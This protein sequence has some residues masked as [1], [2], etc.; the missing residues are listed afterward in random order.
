M[1]VSAKAGCAEIVLSTDKNIIIN[2]MAPK[3]MAYVRRGEVIEPC[4]GINSYE[5]DEI[6]ILFGNPWTL[7]TLFIDYL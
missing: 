4:H 3:Q 7:I 2:S 5:N 6:I 1:I